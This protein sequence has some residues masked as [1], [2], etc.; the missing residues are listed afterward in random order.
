MKKIEKILQNPYVLFL[1]FLIAFIFYVLFNPTNGAGGDEP[2][3]LF[4]AK[5]LLQ[6]YYSPPGKP[7]YLING[8]G[9]PII[10]MPFVALNVP[11]VYMALMNPFFYYFSIILLYKALNKIVT[12]KLV[13]AF[14]L[15]WASYLIA[16]QSLPYIHTEVFTYFLITL[17]IYSTNKSI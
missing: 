10:L 14:S 8:P 7:I 11:F 16:Y 5:N 17:L 1:P 9:Y 6:G 15:A 4:Y 12:F 2:R 13:I 3:Y